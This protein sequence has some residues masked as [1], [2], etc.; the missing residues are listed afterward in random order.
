MSAA[1]CAQLGAVAL[2]D[3]RMNHGVGLLGR[4]GMPP[5]PRGRRMPW[6]ADAVLE[7]AVDRRDVAVGHL[8]RV[9]GVVGIVGSP[10]DARVAR[11]PAICSAGCW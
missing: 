9:S 3:A 4:R 7:I 10:V 11:G 6:R 1:R 2:V 5:M 8:G